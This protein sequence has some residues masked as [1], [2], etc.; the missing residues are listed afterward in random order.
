MRLQ[1][2]A[3]RDES[4]F[5]S[6]WDLQKGQ[7]MG[8]WWVKYVILLPGA[9]RFI[10]YLEPCVGGKLACCCAEEPLVPNPFSFLLTFF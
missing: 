3:G 1:T 9:P 10:C 2:D 7:R 4:Y 5:T 6:P 8:D